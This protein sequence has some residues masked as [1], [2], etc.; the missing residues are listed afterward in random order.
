[1]KASVKGHFDRRT[2]FKSAGAAAAGASTLGLLSDAKPRRRGPERQPEV[3]P[4]AAQDHRPAR[5]DRRRRADDLPAHPHR[6]EPGD[7]GLRRG[8]R[9]RE[10][11]VRALPEEPHPRREPVQRGQDL[12]QDQAVR[13]PRAPGG[14]RLRRRDGL[15]GP[16]WK[17]L[18]RPGV[19]DAG[20]EVPRQGQALRRH[21]RVRRPA[22]AGTQAQGT[23][24][25]GLHVPEAGLRHQPAEGRAGGAHQ[26]R[27]DGLRRPRHGDAS[28]SRASRS[29]RRASPG[30]PT[31]LPRSARSSGPR[32]R[33]RPTTTATSTST[34]AS[35]WRGR[36][37][38]I[39]SRGWRTWCRGSSAS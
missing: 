32:C 24:G 28:R 5:R 33:C 27:G 15:L 6:H 11:H 9:R 7:L 13:P 2:F 10:R 34:R 25:P 4:V 38:S 31:G 8:P 21:D 20:R 14:R 3:D 36:W 1:M 22:R 23:H 16:S 39:T 29:P 17:G 18:R 35:G 30:S 12:P 19:P 26:A 37:R